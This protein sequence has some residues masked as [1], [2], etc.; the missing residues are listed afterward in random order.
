MQECE[1]RRWDVFGD[2][3]FEV[4]LYPTITSI[5]S[6]L[7]RINPLPPQQTLSIIEF[8]F[9]KQKYFSNY[10]TSSELHFR[11]CL[12]YLTRSISIH[13]YFFIFLIG[14]KR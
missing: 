9:C 4:T 3:N 1:E 11:L 7:L 8:K 10:K 14:D 13:F 5:T 6:H 12:L 2:N